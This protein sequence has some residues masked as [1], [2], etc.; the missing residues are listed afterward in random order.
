MSEALSQNNPDLIE[1]FCDAMWAESGLA[2]ATLSAYR[3]DLQALSAWA[4]P[5]LL[6]D[7]SK[8]DLIEF[9]HQ[10]VCSELSARTVSRRISSF[11]RLYA[12]LESEGRI[13]SDPSE[14]VRRPAGIRSLPA[15]HEEEQISALLAAPAVD[16]PLGLRDRAIL[17]TMYSSGLRVSEMVSLQWSHVDLQTGVLRLFGKG[18]RERLSPV[19]EEAMHWLLRY[20]KEAREKLLHQGDQSQFLFVCKRS[21]RLSRQMCWHIIKKYA[22]RAG[23]G[24][25]ISPHGLRHAF[26]THLVNR[27][28]DLRTVQ[29]LLG[30]RSLSTTQIYTFVAQARLRGLHRSHH[31]R[32]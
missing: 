18:G 1:A 25:N 22:A 12:W 17:E 26:A 31:P 13:Q 30:H 20:F 23:L 8:D 14:K 27:G 32:G 3:S 16:T 4:R 29:L 11:R 21:G 7:L 15:H 9:C 5:K 28:A 24:Y 6:V 19:G 2:K 10:G